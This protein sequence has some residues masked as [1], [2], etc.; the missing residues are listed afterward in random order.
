MT[1]LNEKGKDWN[2]LIVWCLFEL[3][4]ELEEAAPASLELDPDRRLERRPSQ[5]AD[6]LSISNI[7]EHLITYGIAH[8]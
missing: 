2:F 6:M 3:Q 4:G 1:Q 7:T 8:A 5:Q